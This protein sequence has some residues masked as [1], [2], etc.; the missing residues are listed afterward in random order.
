MTYRGWGN[1]CKAKFGFFGGQV[2]KNNNTDNHA[3]LGLA[4]II[5]KG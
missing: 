3:T 1:S 5:A 4:Y 2:Y